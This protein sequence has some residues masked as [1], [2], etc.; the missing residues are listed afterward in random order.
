MRPLSLTINTEKYLSDIVKLEY[1]SN[2]E[3]RQADVVRTDNS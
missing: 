3:P 2:P 1:L